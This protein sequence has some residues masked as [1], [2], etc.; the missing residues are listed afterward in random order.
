MA[1]CRE[2]RGVVR[3]TYSGECSLG[4][5]A[6]NIDVAEKVQSA[7]VPYLVVVVGLAIV[8]LLLVFRSLLVPLNAAGGFLLS[9][10]AALGA[11][12]LVFQQEQARTCWAW[13]PP[14]RS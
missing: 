5:T 10:L 14:G 9:V 8:L 7:L 11:V 4:T 1:R 6:L 13:R 2:G 3:Y 12:V